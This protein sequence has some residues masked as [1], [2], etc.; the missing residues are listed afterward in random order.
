MLTGRLLP[1]ALGQQGGRAQADAAIAAFALVAAP[2]GEEAASGGAGGEVP[3]ASG[4]EE[5]GGGAGA[6]EE[7]EG[8][9]A[10]EIAALGGGGLGGFL[11]RMGEAADALQ[12]RLARLGTACAAAAGDGPNADRQSAAGDD[13]AG[14]AAAAVPE[15]STSAEGGGRAGGAGGG[16][17]ERNSHA[18]SMLRRVRCR[19]EGRVGEA[20]LG[21]A[22][23]VEA[24]IRQATSVDQLAM[25]YE[26]WAPW[27]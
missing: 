13:T 17:Q 15:E 4:E 11:F 16:E 2:V 19:L 3:A 6:E 26:G 25:L 8:E 10:A 9:I 22:E 18:L 24:M 21:V 23:Q 1:H 12:L 14:G 5:D 20:R 27:V 7:G